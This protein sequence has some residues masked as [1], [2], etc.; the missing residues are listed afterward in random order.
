MRQVAAYYEKHKSDYVK[1]EMLRLSH[2]FL[3]AS[4]QDASRAEKK[5]QAEELVKE[6]RAL[7][8]LDY[9]SFGKLVEK[10]SEEP[11]TKPLRGDMRYLSADD[12]AKEYGAEVATAAKGMGKTIGMVSEV[13]ETPEGLHVLKLQGHQPA[14]NLGVDQVRTQI[15]ARL[16]YERRT[17]DFNT[18]VESLKSKAKLQIH[19]E[20]LSKLE[21]DL[22]APAKDGKDPQRGTLPAPV[23]AGATSQHR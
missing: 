6:A 10:H 8:P 14:L 19:D 9:A 22:K 15:Q 1:P 13:V 4:A 5:K 20:T 18:F 11:R 17:E 16:L 23:P 3:K 21:I 7:Q 12:L 2:I